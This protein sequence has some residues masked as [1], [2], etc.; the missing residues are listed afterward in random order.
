MWP[1]KSHSEEVKSLI[2]RAKTGDCEAQ[3]LLAGHYLEGVEGLERSPAEAL[4]WFTQAAAK[5]DVQA[6]YFLGKMYLDGLGVPQDDVEA[7]RW[8]SVA[9]NNRYIYT[10]D[11]YGTYTAMALNL[12][13]NQYIELAEERLAALRAT[14]DDEQIT[15]ARR[16]IDQWYAAKADNGDP[17]A[18]VWLADKYFSGENFPQDYVKAY[19]WYKIAQNSFYFIKNHGCDQTLAASANAH[20]KLVE[21]KLQKL[22]KSIDLA[23]MKQG[24]VLLANWYKKAA[25]R[26]VASAERAMEGW[27]NETKG[28]V[29]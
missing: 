16:D 9:A 14:M 26:G 21:D 22:E 28:C 25:K 7:Y 27:D 11:E 17:D 10:R 12:E 15:A 23:Q 4:K 3:C 1:F 24:S 29:L 6:Q 5:D 2:T 13:K 18:Q 19:Q 20:L 8:F